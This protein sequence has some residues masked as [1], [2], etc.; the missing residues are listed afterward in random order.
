MSTAAVA[1]SV[2]MRTCCSSSEIRRCASAAKCAAEEER[3]VPQEGQAGW[4]VDG[5]GAGG[6]R[7]VV[8]VDTVMEDLVR[9]GFSHQS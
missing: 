5:R 9:G 6:A 4:F 8:A 3:S 7:M 1:L 2:R